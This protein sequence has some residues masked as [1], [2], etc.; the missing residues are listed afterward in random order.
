MKAKLIAPCGM[1]CNICMAYLRDK[2]HC[3][4]CRE[5][6]K[7]KTKTRYHCI[8]RD[9]KTIKKNNWKFCSDKCEQFPCQRMKSLDKRYRT[10]YEMSMLE[11]LEYIKKKGIRKFVRKEENRW[12][13]P[14]CGGVINVHR[15]IC[16]T[17]GKQ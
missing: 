16:S 6:H 2:N 17:C 3:N 8:I 15:K 12:C 7:N 13:C 4:G 9:C 5:I 14:E 11:N 1:N 10:K